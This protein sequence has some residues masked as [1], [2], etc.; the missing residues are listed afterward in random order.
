MSTKRDFYEVLNVARDATPEQVKRAYKK[1]A[2]ANHPD[3]NPGDEGAVE[4]FKSASEAY[5]V[6]SDPDKRSRYDRYGHAG[7]SGFGGGGAGRAGFHDASD[8]FE[9]FGDIFEGF[10]F[11]GGGGGGRRAS[12]RPRQGASLKTSIKINLHE[13]ASGCKQTIELNRHQTCETC[14]G[15]GAAPGSSPEVCDYCGGH[16]KVVQ[17]QGFFRVQTTCPACGGSG[18]TIKEKCSDCRGS[19]QIMEKTELELTIPPGIDEGMQLCLRG[20]GEP[21]TNGGP[22]GDLY[23]NVHVK[24]HQFFD[25][26]GKHLHCRVPITYSQ[27]A[28]GANIDIPTLSGPHNLTIPAGTQPGEQIRMKGMGMPDVHGGREG[29]LIV[30]MQLEVP[31]KLTE[32]QEEKLRELAELEHKHVSPHRKSFFENLKEYFTSITSSEE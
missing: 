10:G 7:L 17:S 18:Q 19:G 24:P 5:D 27:A 13:A 8:I 25:R 2:L 26:D 14:D 16:G 4:R 3:R 31:T 15:S 22:R 30:E 29:D 9:A 6:L 1:V 32:Q 12:N 28:L 21:G 20:E 23:V 11:G